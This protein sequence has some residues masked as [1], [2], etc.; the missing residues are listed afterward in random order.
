MGVN[1]ATTFAFLRR[2]SLTQGIGLWEIGVKIE[3]ITAYFIFYIKKREF[4][5]FAISVQ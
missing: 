4:D 5:T 3:A 2:C 1:V